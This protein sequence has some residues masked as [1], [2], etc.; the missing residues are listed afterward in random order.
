MVYKTGSTLEV[1]SSM[2]FDP[3]E[4]DMLRSHIETH[5]AESK[6]Y[7]WTPHPE[8]QLTTIRGQGEVITTRL[9]DY[10][11]Q[12]SVYRKCSRLEL[13]RLWIRHRG[14]IRVYEVSPTSG[15]GTSAGPN[16]MPIWKA[17]FN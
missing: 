9:E 1:T 8:Y 11:P 12:I 13:F 3:T 6:G 7:K 10:S 14:T 5:L 4:V 17:L 16:T 2:K 15:G